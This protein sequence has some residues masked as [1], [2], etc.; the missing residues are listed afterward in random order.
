MTKRKRGGNI[1]QR[2]NS[3]LDG[4]WPLRRS[5]GKICAVS[6]FLPE[7]S[8]ARDLFIPYMEGGGG[9][10][11]MW[12]LNFFTTVYTNFLFRHP[13]GAALGFFQATRACTRQN[14][15]PYT[16]VRVLIGTGHGLGITHG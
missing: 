2:S 16:R 7:N 15:Y 12:P 6:L 14:P 11:P 8:N 10:A 13:L 4:H 5:G 1:L 9:G 3:C